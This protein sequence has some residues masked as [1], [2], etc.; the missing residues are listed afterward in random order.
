V[1]KFSENV[2][3]F[4]SQCELANIN[5]CQISKVQKLGP[6]PTALALPK[7]KPAGQKPSQAKKKA[8]L[9]LAFFGLAWPGFRLQAGAGTSLLTSRF[10]FACP[11]MFCHVLN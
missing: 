9:G 8:Q 4:I 7:P 1:K 6:R 2:K 11:S 5:L 10:G 3:I